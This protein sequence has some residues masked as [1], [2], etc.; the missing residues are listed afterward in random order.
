[1]SYIHLTI[2]KRSQIEVLRKEGYSV[3]RIASLI[4]VHHSTVARE[5]NRVEGEYSAIKMQQ[6]AISKSANKTR[7]IKSTSQLAALIESSL[8]QSRAL[9]ELV[10]DKLVG[11]LSFK[12]I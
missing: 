10:Y 3:R 1:M 8:Q 12:T 4:G 6:L 7:S 9:E 11:V 2:E 5:L